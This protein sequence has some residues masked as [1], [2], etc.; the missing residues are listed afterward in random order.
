MTKTNERLIRDVAE[1]LAWEPSVTARDLAVDAKDGVVTL[2]GTVSSLR[3]HDDVLA[4]ANRVRGVAA[5]AD[6][7]EVR[8]A[9]ASERVDSDL[10]LAVSNALRWNAAVP[11]ERIQIVVHDGIV[12]LTGD[13]D[14]QYQREAACRAVRQLVGVK[15]LV[16]AI[17]VKPLVSSAEIKTDIEAALRRYADEDAGH[18]HVETRGS[19]VVLTG[20]VH[21]PGERECAEHA[22]W[23]APGVEK[24]RNEIGI[25]R[26]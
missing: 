1:E 21:A 25:L 16:D 11:D 7:L 13:V 17:A 19:E 22:A 23:A 3:E 8:L 2:R 5:V 4:A 10:A 24:V 9:P 26:E 15:G 20:F 12:T 18:I 6:E 14:W